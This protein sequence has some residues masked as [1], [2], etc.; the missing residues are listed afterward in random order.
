VKKLLKRS[1]LAAT[2]IVI[3]A[4]ALLVGPVAAHAAP[5][6]GGGTTSAT[7]ILATGTG[8]GS[9][10]YSGTITGNLDVPAG[11]RLVVN[12]A[13]VT[14][15]VT[16]EGSLFL[17]NTTVDGNVNVQGGN[18][19]T[20]N[21]PVTIKG[22]VTITGSDNSDTG[23]FSPTYIGKNLNYYGNAGPLFINGN[24]LHVAG[25]TNIS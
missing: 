15:N 20:D 21:Q 16:V 6:T 18:F 9:V 17:I 7:A 23:F 1:L 13:E 10:P 19:K 25:Q 14:G 11:V 5:N 12:G 22:V 4:G 2:S 8:T 3:P 24:V